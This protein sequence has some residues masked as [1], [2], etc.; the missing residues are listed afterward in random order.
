METDATERHP[1]AEEEGEREGGGPGPGC[2][3]G[4]GD[5]SWVT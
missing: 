4:A 5:Y 1:E 3:T 2:R